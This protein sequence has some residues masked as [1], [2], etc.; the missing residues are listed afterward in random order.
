MLQTFPSLANDLKQKKAKIGM[1]LGSG[2][3]VLA[4]MI[5]NK[6]EFS[7]QDIPELNFQC[8]VKGHQGKLVVGEIGVNTVACMQGRPHWYE[9]AT[10]ESF[11]QSMRLFKALGCD[12]VVLT[13]ASGAI[14]RS[15]QVG[16][17]VLIK[18]HI[19]MQGKNPLVGIKPVSFV[20]MENT[21]D[22][23]LR[24]Q[25]INLAKKADIPLKQGI[26][27]GVLGP[28][29]ETPAEIQAFA[30]MGAD[31]I[32][33]STVPEAIAARHLGLKVVALAVI[34]NHAAGISEIPLSHNLTLEGA[35]EGQKKAIT[36]IKEF[37]EFS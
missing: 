15:M 33:M 2:L 21:Y 30:T 17:L 25:L 18:D 3:G 24:H 34:S 27:C 1:V 32:G 14:D 26:Y 29:F 11:I 13:N 16:D 19:N 8:S 12:T 23:K 6:L 9:G 37:I 28:S 22:I 36:L 35:L 5:Q 31:L 20:G 10:S 7:Y 4:D